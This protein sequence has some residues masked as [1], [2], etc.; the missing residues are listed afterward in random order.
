[1]KED[2]K[3]KD[4]K[5]KLYFTIDMQNFISY[6]LEQKTNCE[7]IFEENKKYNIFKTL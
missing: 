5:R 4:G 3:P 7:I 6:N 2:I 1:M